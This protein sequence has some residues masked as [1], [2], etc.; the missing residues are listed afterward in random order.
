M[1]YS[2][3][4]GKRKEAFP[5]GTGICD[6]ENDFNGVEFKKWLTELIPDIHEY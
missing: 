5:Y 2:I 6:F 4:G 1:K 3:V